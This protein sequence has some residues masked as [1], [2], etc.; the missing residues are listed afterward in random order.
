MNKINFNRSVNRFGELARSKITASRKELITYIC[1][2]SERN[3]LVV[4]F[5]D[6]LWSSESK[7]LTKSP[8]IYVGVGMTTILTLNSIKHLMPRLL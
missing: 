4:I 5:I 1:P 6:N 2:F 7:K 3:L 8:R